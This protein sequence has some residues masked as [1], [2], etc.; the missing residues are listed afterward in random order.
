MLIL[1]AIDLMNGEVVRLRQG[2]ASE[3]TVYSND[4]VA[5]A[6]KWQDEGGDYLHIV[7]LDAAFSGESRNLQIVEKIAGAV[8]IPCELGG[9]MRSE[10]AVQQAFKAGVTRVVIGTR[11]S[12][13]I[14]FVRELC[15]KFGGEKIAVGID[16]KNGMVSIKG[17]TELSQTSALELALNAEAAGVGTII[18]T[19][20]ATDGMLSGPNFKEL[21]KMLSS[22]RC[23]LIASGGVSCAADV[24]RLRSMPGLYGAIIGKALY[25]EKIDLR[26]L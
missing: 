16:A 11:A 18:Y 22:L 1:P 23:Q 20:I 6:K 5:F 4:P 14:E 21:E 17:W 9:G 2:I 7:D 13:S 10:E 26:R 24:Q 8:S 12:E 15:Q 19:D 25:D 3:K